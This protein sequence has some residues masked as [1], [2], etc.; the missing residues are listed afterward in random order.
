MS[1]TP[2]VLTNKQSL[3]RLSGQRVRLIGKVC[4]MS[5]DG[6][7]VRVMAPDG[8]EIRCRLNTYPR[9]SGEV[10]VVQVTGVAEQDGT[11]ISAD[12]PVLELGVDIDLQLLNEAINLQFAKPFQH[13]FLPGVV[14][15]AF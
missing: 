15:P 6:A 1:T 3:A 9:P 5:P 10:L 2:A 8:V 4:G 7:F 13:L 12:S 11:T 14:A